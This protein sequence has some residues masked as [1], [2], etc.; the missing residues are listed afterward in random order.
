M[1]YGRSAAKKIADRAVGADMGR[2]PPRRTALMRENA[3]RA[4][5]RGRLRIPSRGLSSS[6]LIPRLPPPDWL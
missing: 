4:R 3:L 5:K 1:A 2:A 6:I